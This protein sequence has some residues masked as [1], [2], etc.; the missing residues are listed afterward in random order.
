MLVIYQLWKKLVHI[1]IGKAAF[2]A[3]LI[4]IVLNNDNNNYREYR[5]KTIHEISQD[6]TIIKYTQRQTFYFDENASAPLKD[7][8][9]IML[10]NVPMNA[11]YQFFFIYNM[12]IYIH[13]K[14]FNH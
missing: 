14:D 9:K 8:D 13:F 2:C 12:I 7:T 5:K 3:S 6:K 10:L 11:S 1:S 4:I